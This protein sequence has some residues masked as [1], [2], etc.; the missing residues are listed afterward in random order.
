MRVK[1][2]FNFVDGNGNSTYFFQKIIDVDVSNSD[3]PLINCKIKKSI[4]DHSIRPDHSLCVSWQVEYSNIFGLKALP[5][6]E[7]DNQN[8]VKEKKLDFIF[9]N[10]NLA[11]Q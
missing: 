2:F 1:F 6:P 5:H 4:F 10:E 7:G 9:K 8:Q 3:K 11:G